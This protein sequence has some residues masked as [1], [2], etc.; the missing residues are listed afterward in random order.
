MSNLKKFN[1]TLKDF[2]QEVEQLKDVS[3]AYKK[4]EQL[5]ETYNQILETFDKNNLTQ[6]KISE[7]TKTQ[8]EKV[9]KGL[10]E[11]KNINNQNIA[12]L[13]RLIE[14]KTDQIRKENKEFYKDL[15]S[16]LRIRL[17]D[18]TAEIKHLIERERTQIKQIFENEFA[19]N[20]EELKEEV[21][22][23]TKNLT[24]LLVFNNKQIKIL[25]W[26]IGGGVLI[27][28]LLNMLKLWF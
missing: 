20:T 5:V 18:N 25:M 4:I 3:I 23:V 11:I 8:H 16:T 28:S 22:E 10:E 17:D 12:S 21:K 26:I 14:V 24:K 6:I 1:Q 19:K 9:I 2:S 7:L 15:E 13:L 27:I